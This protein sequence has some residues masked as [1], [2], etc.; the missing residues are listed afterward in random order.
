MRLSAVVVVALGLLGC[1]GGQGSTAPKVGGAPWI[2][3][4][5]LQ[6]RGPYQLLVDLT[7]APHRMHQV[8]YALHSA[9]LHRWTPPTKVAWG[10]SAIDM[11]VVGDGGV[12]LVGSTIPDPSRGLHAPFSSIF[13]LSTA[14]LSDWGSHRWVIEDARNPMIVDPDLTVDR[15][16]RVG[17]VYYSAPQPADPAQLPEHHPGPH[18]IRVAWWEGGADGRF[19]EQAQ[20]IV[21]VEGMVDPSLCFFD[22]GWHLFTSGPRGVAHFSGTS[23]TEGLAR[24]RYFQ[25]GQGSVPSCI[26]DGDSLMV[27]AQRSGGRGAPQ[28]RRFNAKTQWSDAV[29]LFPSGTDPFSGGCASPTLGRRDGSWLLFCAVHTAPEPGGQQSRGPKRR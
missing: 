12:V 28:V 3:A 19:V 17:A 11:L 29:D 20:P 10:W 24:D 22:G 26:V 23:L 16:G 27:V 14:D 5:D 21:S 8:V 6:Y 9:D 4:A 13:A 7:Q 15:S 18:D 25:W 1:S 2:N